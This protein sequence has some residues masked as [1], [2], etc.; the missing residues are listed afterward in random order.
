MPR[1]YTIASS[2]LA[3]PNQIRIAISLTYHNPTRK[4]GF[5]SKFLRDAKTATDAGQV[6]TA[7][8]F[9]KDSGFK[10]PL[11]NTVA[12]VIMVGPGTG[13]APFLGFIEERF[14]LSDKSASQKP[15]IFHGPTHLFFGC[16]RSDSDYIFKDK[17]EYGLA[18][19]CL[20]NLHVAF[21]R[22]GKRQYVQDLMSE[23]K[24]T[25]SWLIEDERAYVFLCGNTGMGA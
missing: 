8:A 4:L 24:E 5:A 6:I 9:I 13:V 14:H 2:S 15:M 11:L 21:S 22:E 1:Y 19:G 17:I 20:S 25:L 16:R 10:M 18:S 7:A 12:P 23:I 3:N